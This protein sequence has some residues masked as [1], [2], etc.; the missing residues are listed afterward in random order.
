MQNDATRSTF[1]VALAFREGIES[2][3]VYRDCPASR[4]QAYACVMPV[5]QY[6]L[7]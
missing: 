7:E 1:L 5:R 4:D 3:L 2:D 6:S